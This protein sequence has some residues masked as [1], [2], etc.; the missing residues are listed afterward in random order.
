LRVG[1]AGRS[2]RRQ[3]HEFHCRRICHER[4]KRASKKFTFCSS[5]AQGAAASEN[6]AKTAGRNRSPRH[7]E[8][9][10]AIH[11]STSAGATGCVVSCCCGSRHRGMRLGEERGGPG[12]LWKDLDF[13]RLGRAGRSRRRQPHEFHCRRICHERRKRASKSS[14]F[15]L[16]WRRVRRRARIRQRKPGR[17]APPSLRTQRRT[18]PLHE[19]F[20]RS[21]RSAGRVVNCFCGLRRRRT[22]RREIDERA[23]AGQWTG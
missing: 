5:L 22:R 3:P 9:S 18:P 20:S 13:L 7:C 14:L 17:T 15:V 6:T 2:R 10:D 1:R 12:P 16:A 19:T 23:G 11:L 4:R 21:A 8:R